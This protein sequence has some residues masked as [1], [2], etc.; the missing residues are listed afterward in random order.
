M[1]DQKE[2]LANA[3]AVDIAAQLHSVKIGKAILSVPPQPTVPPPPVHELTL[4]QEDDDPF[5]GNVNNR[6]VAER[7]AAQ[8][9]TI[10]TNVH[11]IVHTGDPGKAA[12]DIE[13]S[14]R[15]NPDALSDA[16]KDEIANRE[17]AA[18]LAEA[19]PSAGS[20]A[21]QRQA[22]DRAKSAENAANAPINRQTPDP[23]LAPVP[24]KPNAGPA[25]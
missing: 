16:E 8:N 21:A 22:E 11:K 14:L 3:A 2:L 7:I 4:I 13:Q 17:L 20:P 1:A 6:K 15:V 23:A 9:R 12:R 5:N 19:K 18:K 25:K 24:W 10:Y